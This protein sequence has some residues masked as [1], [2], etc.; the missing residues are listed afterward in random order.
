[1]FNVAESKLYIVM[2]Q[3][4]GVELP[5]VVG[6]AL[7]KNERI[8][9]IPHEELTID[10]VDTCHC[11][12]MQNFEAWHPASQAPPPNPVCDQLYHQS[13]FDPR[14]MYYCGRREKAWD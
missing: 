12:H 4:L 1:M 9:A 6:P 3:L 2:M 13:T 7:T 10:Q 14:V 5:D 8:S 11:A